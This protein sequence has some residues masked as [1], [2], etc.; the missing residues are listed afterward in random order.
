[1]N[2]QI[3]IQGNNLPEVTP[4]TDLVGASDIKNFNEL[5][6]ELRTALEEKWMNMWFI[7]DRISYVINEAYQLN[8]K[9]DEAPDFK[10][11]LE[12]S[13]L[14]LKVYW[15]DLSDKKTQIAVFNNIPAKWE[16]LNF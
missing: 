2:K 9:W 7:V 11:I 10:T 12:A 16:K 4:T 8:N 14:L 3:I 15:F 1:M 5:Q 6:Q 13:K